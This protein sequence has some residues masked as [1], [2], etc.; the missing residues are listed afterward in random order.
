MPVL[1][2]E[3]ELLVFD[4]L[5]ALAWALAVFASPLLAAGVKLFKTVGKV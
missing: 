1:L 4:V 3:S 2:L 5:A